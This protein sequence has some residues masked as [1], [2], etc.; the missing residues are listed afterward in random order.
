MKK[1]LLSLLLIPIVL[2]CSSGSNKQ[3]SPENNKSEVVQEQSNFF[4][5]YLALKDALVKTNATEASKAAQEFAASFQKEVSN[6]SI[7][8]A[9]RSI[10]VSTDVEAQRTAFKVITDGLIEHVKS[11]ESDGTIYV[12]Y[13]PM[14]FNNTGA[15]WLSDSQEIFNP[16]FGDKMLKCGSVKEK[17]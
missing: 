12:Q 2:S 11:G 13:C 3:D 14:A 6:E 9:A 15:S 17:I 1:N 5:D 7:I 4:T 16:Y 10:A 8:D